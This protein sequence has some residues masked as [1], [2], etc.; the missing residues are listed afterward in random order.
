MPWITNT[1]SLVS[2]FGQCTTLDCNPFGCFFFFHCFI[3]FETSSLSFHFRGNGLGI[4]LNA[5]LVI[6]P[7]RWRSVVLVSIYLYYDE[8][9]TNATKVSANG[10]HTIRFRWPV[11][12]ATMNFQLVANRIEWDI[13][14]NCSSFVFVFCL[15]LRLSSL[16][17][18]LRQ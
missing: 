11:N 13:E 1:G 8:N 2:L 12:V 9:Q 3:M 18:G 10:W 16:C 4:F 17:F 5:S 14:T 6:E 7:F 15:W